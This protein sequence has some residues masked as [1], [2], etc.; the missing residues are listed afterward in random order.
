M[1]M[2]T[3]FLSLHVHPS[4]SSWVEVIFGFAPRFN[5]V[6]KNVTK[7]KSF[8]SLRVALPSFCYLTSDVVFVLILEEI[9]S[10]KIAD[11]LLAMRYREKL[12]RQKTGVINPKIYYDDMFCYSWNIVK[13]IAGGE[14][15]VME[16]NDKKLSAM[17]TSIWSLSFRNVSL[18]SLVIK[19]WFAESLISDEESRDALRAVNRKWLSSPNDFHNLC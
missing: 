2:I 5:G 15:I 19:K 10:T 6:M 1:E 7:Y 16:A 14:C 3:I 18:T 9:D 8:S 12:R 17:I 13:C 4:S 11:N